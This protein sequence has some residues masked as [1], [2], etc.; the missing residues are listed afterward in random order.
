MNFTAA[1]EVAQCSTAQHSTAQG[2]TLCWELYLGQ[3]VGARGVERG[4]HELV[5][6]E[7]RVVRRRPI[8]SAPRV[9]LSALLQQRLAQ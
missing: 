1:S 2:G 6:V 7:G 5:P 8:R 4:E 9:Q 3:E